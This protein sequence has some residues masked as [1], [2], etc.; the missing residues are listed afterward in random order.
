MSLATGLTATGSTQGTALL[1]TAA[2]NYVSTT[3]ASTGVRLP[4]DGRFTDVSIRNGGANTLNIYPPVNY[5][6][7][8]AS[9][10][11]ALTLGAGAYARVR[12]DANGNWWRV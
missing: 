4:D 5:A 8:G 2:N 9:V 12:R 1:L 11:A 7:D 6:I 10:N 3:A